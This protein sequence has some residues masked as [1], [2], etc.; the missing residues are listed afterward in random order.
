MYR[1]A[2]LAAALLPTLAGAKSWNGIEPGVSKL[3]D[4]VQKFGE[5]SKRV[6][7][8]GVEILAYLGDKAIRG[9]QQSQ[10]KVN[11]AS[12]VVER[13]DV[14]PGPVIDKDAVENTYGRS[15]PPGP[16]PGAGCYVKK[17]TD[18]FRTYFQYAK[19]GLAVF[20]SDD[21]KTVQSFIFTQPKS[22]TSGAAR[23]AH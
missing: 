1:A 12:Q 18:D 20:F 14:F 6:R 19:L 15:C 13:I 10:F 2:A 4:V 7:S 8:E 5:P 11:P 9:T 23:A 3:D 17:V 21:G 16:P 22:D